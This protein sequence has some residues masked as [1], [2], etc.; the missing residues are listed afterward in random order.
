MSIMLTSSCTINC[1]NK[2]KARAMTTSHSPRGLTHWASFRALNTCQFIGALNDN[3]FKLLLVFCFI[4][5]EGIE[6]SNRLLSLAGAVYVLPFLFLATL[7]GTLADRYSK[8]SIIIATRAV[9]LLAL[10][11]GTI[12]FWL[13]NKNCAFFA[14]FLLACHSAIFAPSKYSIVPELVSKQ[15][16]SKANGLLTLCTYTAIIIGTFLA[17]FLTNYTQY[18]FVLASLFPIAFSCIALAS[19]FWIKKTAPAGSHKKMSGKL[20][21][22]LINSLRFIRKEPLLLSCVLGSAFFLFTGSFIQLNIIPFAL[23]SLHLTE[24]EGG[25]MFLLVA[26]GIGIGSTLAGKLSGK[27]VEFGFVPIGGIGLSLCFFLL[28]LFASSLP[29]VLCLVF[30]IG[31]CGGLYLIPLDSYI[32][33]ASPATHRGQVVATSNFFGFFGVLLSAILL[34]C[35]AEFFQLSPQK[36]FAVVGGIVFVIVSLLS[37]SLS[38]HIIRFFAFL[39]GRL[40]SKATIDGKEM[41]STEHPSLFF[42]PHT[43]WPWAPRLLAAQRHRIKFFMLQHQKRAPISALNTV[44]SRFFPTITVGAIDD[45]SPDGQSHDLVIQALK[46]GISIALFTSRKDIEEQ[47][48]KFVA[49]W[50]DTSEGKRIDYF[51]LHPKNKGTSG[52]LE[53]LN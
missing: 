49:A 8:R 51:L 41:I 33:I 34:F 39:Y 46:K 31:V 45:L 7:S 1:K 43:F 53:R 37:L 16:I 36:A 6:Q 9:E 15:D 17:S 38:G 4:H 10:S 42:V 12:G 25:Y 48:K 44:L 27:A 14:L 28:N 40:F 30:L 26:V 21:R 5:I 13:A 32:Q 23:H 29:I 24:V 19:T 47:S 3:L 18:N 20:I 35:T 50:K 22:E 52:K 11:I 2:N